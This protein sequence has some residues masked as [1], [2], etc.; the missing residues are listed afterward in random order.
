MRIDIHYMA[1]ESTIL[2]CLFRICS[3]SYMSA[4]FCRWW[5]VSFCN[6][7]RKRREKWHYTWNHLSAKLLRSEGECKGGKHLFFAYNY[8]FIRIKHAS[9]EEKK[10]FFVSMLKHICVSCETFSILCLGTVYGTH[11]GCA[12]GFIDIFF[13]HSIT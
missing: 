2:I 8:G 1:E 10:H 5:A 12:N 6:K 3:N 13:F 9:S 7:L 11:D 4:L